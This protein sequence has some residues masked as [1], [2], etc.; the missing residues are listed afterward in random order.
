MREVWLTVR[1]SEGAV[2]SCTCPFPDSACGCVHAVLRLAPWR[3]PCDAPERPDVARGG[4]SQVMRIGHG[5]NLPTASHRGDVDERG[6][7]SMAT[8]KRRQRAGLGGGVRWAAN[9]RRHAKAWPILPHARAIADADGPGACTRSESSAMKLVR[10]TQEGH[11]GEAS[12]C[13]DGR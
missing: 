11:E 5:S 7:A 6:G 13:G 2:D 10:V 3:R 1:H 4:G 8:S 12:N 9:S